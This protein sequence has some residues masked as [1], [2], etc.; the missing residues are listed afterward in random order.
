MP[1]T[2]TMTG[3][4]TL[5]I[6]HAT[7]LEILN[8]WLATHMKDPVTATQVKQVSGGVIFD[9]TFEITVKDSKVELAPHET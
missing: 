2:V 4:N 5:T 1:G 8:Y 9:N 7:M 6:N 3:T